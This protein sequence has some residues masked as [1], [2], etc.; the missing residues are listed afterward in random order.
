MSRKIKYINKLEKLEHLSEEEVE[1]LKPVAEE[2]AFRT[3]DYYNSLID[4]D[5][6]DDPLRRLIVPQTD[7]LINWGEL[8][9]SGEKS[10]QPVEGL[11][12]KY[13]STAL[14]LCNDVCAAYCRFCFRKRLFQNDNDEVVKDVSQGIEYI[15]KNKII[16][17]VLLTGGDPLVMSTKRLEVI[18]EQLSAIDHVKIIRIGTKIPGFNPFRITQD[19]SLV[20]LIERYSKKLRIYVMAHFNL[21]R[22]LTD[23]A[24][25]SLDMVRHAGASVVNQTPII[26]GINDSSEELRN[27]FNKLSFIGVQPYYIFSCRPTAGNKSFAVPVEKAYQIFQEAK[28]ENSGLANTA[29]FVMSHKAG[30]VEVVGLTDDNIILKYHNMHDNR[31][32]GDIL[33][34]KRNPEGY[35][36]D[37]FAVINPASANSESVNKVDITI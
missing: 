7:E 13:N 22:E 18:F 2:Y 33:I 23:E 30:K 12:H 37:D 15:R 20:D 32:N 36:F 10:Y 6:P 35:W 24:I 8:D 17:N 25:L 34:C 4:W 1:Q 28:V 29:R 27:L 14:L 21:E 3:N 5:D 9:A 26:R 31:L 16:T 11:E 19:E